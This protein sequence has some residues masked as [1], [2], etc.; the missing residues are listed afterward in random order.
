L[1]K[2]YAPMEHTFKILQENKLI[3]RKMRG[4]IMLNDYRLLL[5]EASIIEK[6]HFNYTNILDY[7]D[8][9]IIGTVLEYT[10]FLREVGKK[11][12]SNSTKLFIVNSPR[13]Y[14]ACNLFKDLLGSKNTYI[15]SS[16]KAALH[17]LGLHNTE[18]KNFLEIN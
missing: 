3:L 6:S 17:H 5:K 8:T 18:L 7:R 10:S 9:T 14:V 15:F 12:Y 16:P 2:P 4:Q 13:V 1:N 11:K